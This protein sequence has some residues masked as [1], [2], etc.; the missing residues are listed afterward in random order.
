[1]IDRSYTLV[2]G[3]AGSGK[4]A[5]IEALVRSN[6]ARWLAAIRVVEAPD[7]E[8]PTVDDAG[9]EETRRWEASGAVDATLLRVPVGWAGDAISVAEA[10]GGSLFVTD[11][12]DRTDE[13]TRKVVQAVKRPWR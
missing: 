4:T 12:R 2:T 6:H 5:L 3:S 7:L 9:N 1:M 11:L 8:G 13:G 10:V